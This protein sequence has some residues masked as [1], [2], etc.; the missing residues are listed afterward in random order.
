MSPCGKHRYPNRLEAMLALSRMDLYVK[1]HRNQ[2]SKAARREEVRAYHC[3]LC[4][5]WHLTSLE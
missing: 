4:S 2:G 5:A 3:V 1:K